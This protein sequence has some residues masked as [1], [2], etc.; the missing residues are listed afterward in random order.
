MF[1]LTK[2]LGLCKLKLVVNGIML[3]LTNSLGLYKLKFVVLIRQQF[4][5]VIKTLRLLS[6]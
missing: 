5:G 2:S 4:H 3:L 1:S 6:T